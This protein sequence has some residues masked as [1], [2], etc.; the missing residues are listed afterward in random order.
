MQLE[1]Q[2]TGWS[3]L[4]TSVSMLLSK[5]IKQHKVDN[6]FDFLHHDGGEIVYPGLREPNGRRGFTN[7]EMIDYCLGLGYAYLVY[8]F[9]PIVMAVDNQGEPIVTN[10]NFDKDKFLQTHDAVL[11]GAFNGYHHAVAWNSTMMTVYNPNGK[12]HALPDTWEIEFGAIITPLG[13][14][15]SKF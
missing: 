4:P 13:N 3:C 15:K 11:W 12:I 14:I 5:Y 6:I 9:K 1:I 2:P 8:D 10:L 7:N